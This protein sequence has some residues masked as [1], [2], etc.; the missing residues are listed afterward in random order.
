MGSGTAR[1]AD[2]M[3]WNQLQQ[4]VRTRNDDF[5]KLLGQNFLL[6][7]QL[8]REKKDATSIQ[9]L[10]V[11]ISGLA[12]LTK[13]I[14]DRKAANDTVPGFSSAAFTIFSRLAESYNNPA[15]LK[16]AGLHFMMEWR[17]PEAALRYFQRALSL[18]ATESAIRSLIEVASIAVQRKDAVKKG[19]PAETGVTAPSSSKANVTRMIRIT[20][21]LLLTKTQRPTPPTK[22]VFGRGMKINTTAALPDSV[23]DSLKEAARELAA[24]NLAHAH[25]LLLKAGKYRVKKDILCGLWA[26]LG[27]ACYQAG[28]HL[29]MEE[30]YTQA[31]VHGPQD[32]N[33]YFNLALAK[34]L[35]RKIAEAEALYKIA[36]KLD[37]ANP[38]V[39]CNLGALYFQNDRIKDA[40][41]AYRGAVEAGPDYARAW[42]NLASALS[43][44]GKIDEALEA[45]KKAIHLRPGYPEA[46]F[47]LSAIYFGKGDAASLT[48]AASALS[49]VVNYAPLAAS[50]NAMLSMIHSRLEQVDSAKASLQRAVESDPKCALLPTVWNE[51]ETA[52]RA[53]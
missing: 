19:A 43:A 8:A 1:V 10:D 20:D 39:W 34:S 9:T 32:S 35:N 31:Y 27:R 40:E 11:I 15:L 28:R 45:C 7:S 47:K 42:E 51:L 26:N 17:L 3:T 22:L 53:S 33:N 36:A 12:D 44:Q 23:T 4:S 50:A 29:E 52:I 38:K 16:Q 2:R 49:Y 37:P 48:E 13:A 5:G 46:Y 30:A 6:L 18:G 21:K 14:E 41:K 25:D 24:G